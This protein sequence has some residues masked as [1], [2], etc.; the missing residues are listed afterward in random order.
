MRHGDACSPHTACA[1]LTC[2]PTTSSPS[3]FS[4]SCT[5]P[6]TPTPL[7]ASF[8]GHVFLHILDGHHLDA[9]ALP[10]PAGF[11]QG[12]ADTPSTAQLADFASVTT[13]CSGSSS[14]SCGAS[15][16]SSSSRRNGGA[17]AGGSGPAAAGCAAGSP[18]AAAAAGAS[19]DE[20]WRAAL[21][22]TQAVVSA[23]YP[24]F[25]AQAERNGWKLQQTML[26]PKE[27]R[28]LKLSVPLQTL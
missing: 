11:R 7:Q 6:A 4:A 26:N 5:R 8:F 25:L 19:A 3:V 18:G 1:L 9:H 21:L 15:S 23:L 13:V 14:R 17:G 28:L 22:R 27:N 24:D 16:S 12:L 2:S 10:L 20:R